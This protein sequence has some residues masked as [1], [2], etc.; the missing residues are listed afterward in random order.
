MRL[1]TRNT[2]HCNSKPAGSEARICTTSWAPHC[3]GIASM[4][5]PTCAGWILSTISY[6]AIV[7]GGAP[8]TVGLFRQ[9]IRCSIGFRICI[10][11]GLNVSNGASPDRLDQALQPP[12]C[13][14]C[15]AQDGITS[16]HRAWTRLQGVYLHLIAP[17][18]TCSC[19]D[20]VEGPS[21][22]SLRSHELRR[23]IRLSLPL[24]YRLCLLKRHFCSPG[25]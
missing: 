14:R 16:L 2:G 24:R 13:Y 9:C 25:S 1:S 3:D 20:G 17:R 22:P 6:I 11:L 23:L 10:L 15:G 21:A 12:P 18:Q 19:C 4:F 7:S 8:Y 5:H